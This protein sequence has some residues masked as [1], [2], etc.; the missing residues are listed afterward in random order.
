MLCCNT[1][2]QTH[3]HTSTR[4]HACVNGTKLCLRVGKKSCAALFQFFPSMHL[5]LCLLTLFCSAA[6]PIFDLHM[7]ESTHTNTRTHTVP[8]THTDTHTQG[9]A[10]IAIFP[11]RSARSK[12]LSGETESAARNVFVAHL[13][14]GHIPAKDASQRIRGQCT[15]RKILEKQRKTQNKKNQQLHKVKNKLKIDENTN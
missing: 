6:S 8:Y 7:V 13:N 12:Q 5:A 2:K 15:K 3:T 4:T 1:H 9:Q 10:G 11:I 14:L